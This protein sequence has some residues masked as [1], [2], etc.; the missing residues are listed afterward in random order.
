MKKRSHKKK[1]ETDIEAPEVLA[2]P[3]PDDGEAK[4]AAEPVPEEVKRGRH[5]ADCQCPLHAGGKQ[6]PK[7]K[8]KP[9]PTMGGMFVRGSKGYKLHPRVSKM[10][11]IGPLML[12]SGIASTPLFNVLLPYEP[13]DIEGCQEIFEAW[14]DEIGLNIG[15]GW[16]YGLLCGITLAKAIKNAEEITPEMREAMK[17]AKKAQKEA[18][19]AE[20]LR[21]AQAMQKA[22]EQTK[23]GA[24]NPT[25]TAPT[26]PKPEAQA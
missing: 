8:K 10:A 17:A 14:M 11:A 18:M 25:T 13:E 4:T 24:V 21:R 9:D 15:P 6:G 22:A 2:A 1:P 16:Q 23:N 5:P 26:E 20:A 3:K 19:Q 12:A 7:A